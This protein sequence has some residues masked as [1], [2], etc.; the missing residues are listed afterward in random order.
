MENKY[1]CFVIKNLS[2]GKYFWLGWRPF[3]MAKLFKTKEEA[4]KQANEF[5]EKGYQVEVK[6][7]LVIEPI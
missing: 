3:Q 2:N 5:R 1:T 7:V 4:E 6:E